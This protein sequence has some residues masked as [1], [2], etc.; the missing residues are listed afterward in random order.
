[1]AKKTLQE[2]ANF[3][4]MAVAVDEDGDVFMHPTMPTRSSCN[5]YNHGE[6]IF[7]I[8]SDLVEF[9]GDWRDSLTLPENWTK[10]PPFKKGEIVV[11]TIPAP[12]LAGAISRWNDCKVAE[13]WRRPTESEWRVLRGE[14]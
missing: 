8:E 12:G 13:H 5:W 4:D 10:E 1:M 3:F 14:E 7:P 2:I 11:A 6:D 9:S